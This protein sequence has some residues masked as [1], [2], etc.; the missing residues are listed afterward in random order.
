MGMPIPTVCESVPT[1]EVKVILIHEVDDEFDGVL[2]L[3]QLTIKNISTI[4]REKP[5]KYLFIIHYKYPGAVKLAGKNRIIIKN[6]I[7]SSTTLTLV[8][9]CFYLFPDFLKNYFTNLLG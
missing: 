5:V 7:T 1:G 9:G 4:I 2:F 3:L 6:L 8:K